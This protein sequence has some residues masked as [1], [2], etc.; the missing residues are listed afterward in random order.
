MMRRRTLSRIVPTLLL[1]LCLPLMAQEQKGWI[2]DSLG[3]N[4]SA[5]KPDAQQV[6]DVLLKML[7]RWNSHD[8]E[9]HLEVYWD[10]LNCL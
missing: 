10:L 5:T 8:I 2:F 7:D 1:C 9:G 6:Y 4:P 3:S